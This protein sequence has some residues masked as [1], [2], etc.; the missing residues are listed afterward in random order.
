MGNHDTGY[1]KLF[2]HPEM[3][4]DLLRGFVKEDWVQELDFSTLTRE[5]NSYVSEELRERHDDMVWR[6]RFRGRW[7]YLYL[8]LEFQSR[9]DPWMVV[10]MLVYLGLLYQDILN[11][12]QNRLEKL[13][14]VLPIVLYNGAPR[15][16]EAVS[17]AELL[18]DMPAGLQAYQPGLRYL[19]LDEGIFTEEEL[20]GTRNLA[21]AL[22]RLEKSREPE[23]LRQVLAN[24]IEWLQAPEQLRLRRSFAVWVGRV[25]LPR[26]LQGEN[27]PEIEN[28]QEVHAMLA[29][30]VE[31]WTKNWKQQGLQ[32]GLQQGRQEGRQEGQQQGLQES[33]MRLLSK[34]FGPVPNDVAQRVTIAPPEQITRWFDQAIDAPSLD[35][36]F[37]N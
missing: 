16:T 13:P 22:F 24:L 21:A 30:R 18:P 5:F 23:D 20:T 9:P 34:R 6:V 29:E 33:F 8:L 12:S 3:V 10:R 17:L 25:L 7:L 28:L 31:E 2:S 4:E 1:K 32:E 26:R 14:A 35:K 36:V 37:D 27:L 19:L 11:S 15:W